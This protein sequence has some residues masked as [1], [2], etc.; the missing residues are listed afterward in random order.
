VAKIQ[1]L[2]FDKDGCLFDFHATWSV[3]T[4][5]F[6]QGEAAGDAGLLARLAAGF[7]FDLGADR[8]FPDSP[9]IA[10]TPDDLADVLMQVTGADNRAAMI[11]RM[12]R[13]T[14]D[15][16][17]KPVVPLQPLFAGL[18]ARGLVLG[19]AT[20]DAVAPAIAHLKAANVLE[21]FDF[22]AGYDSGFG[23][24]PAP[25][26]MH[27]FCAATGLAPE[28]CLMIGDSLHDLHAGRAAGMGCI[29]VLTGLASTA[30]LAPHADVVLADIGEIPAWLDQ[31]QEQGLG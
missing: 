18:R 10:G 30:E 2:L 24:K 21:Q 25:G 19:L 3:W 31:Q 9:V 20:N 29:G 23:G 13:I 17:Q 14:A 1:G 4:R 22:I 28:N 26:Q 15:V 12:N 7:G 11:A 8:F 6:L 16:P 5:K 27:G